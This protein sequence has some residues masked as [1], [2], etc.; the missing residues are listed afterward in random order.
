MSIFYKTSL[1]GNTMQPR[2]TPL[3]LTLYEKL[4]NEIAAGL[5]PYSARLPSKRTLAQENGVSLVTVEHALELLS[6]EGYLEARER[7]GYYSVYTS[8]SVFDAPK[9]S[10]PDAQTAK[11][12][13]EDAFPFSLMA[14]TMRRV[15]A[16]YGESI[17]IKSPNE[18]LPELRNAI[19]RYLGRS[20][21]IRVSPE[22]IWI[23]AGAEYIYSLLVTA[24]GSDRIFAIESPSYEKIEAVYGAAGVPL[25]LLP[26]RTNGIDSE[27]LRKTDAKILHITPYR[28]YPTGAT[29]TAS[30]RTEYLNWAENGRI[31]IEDDAESELRPGRKP[32]P[33][34]FAQTN[35][36]NVIYLNTFS[37]T[38]APSIRMGYMLLPK[39][40]LPLFRERV[41]F[42]SCTV[43]TFEQLVLA[44]L[45]DSGNFERQLNK[46]RRN[47][48]KF[49]D[50]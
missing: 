26:L 30:K 5:Y 15:L 48:K 31:L 17:L 9:A 7:S 36:E 45:L 12:S 24:I 27:A 23:G 22:Q 13:P 25:R 19:A 20:R 8:G 11:L 4:K 32:G 35:A 49:L 34:L 41:G 16:D 40:M 28:S 6:D 37:R 38:V 43:P 33:T 2:S 46:R 29:A 18:G 42:F 21:D 47:K 44:T 39:K 1:K 50:K 10:F 14:K 3:Y